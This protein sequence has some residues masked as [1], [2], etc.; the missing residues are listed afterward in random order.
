MTAHP[1]QVV[2]KKGTKPPGPFLSFFFPFFFYPPSLKKKK[3]YMTTAGFGQTRHGRNINSAQSGASRG[4]RC[5]GCPGVAPASAAWAVA[6]GS[7][8]AFLLCCL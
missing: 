1:G 3:G 7:P 2:S 4:L 6:V 8:S 5:P